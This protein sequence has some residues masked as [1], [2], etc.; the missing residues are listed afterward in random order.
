MTLPISILLDFLVNHPDNVGLR[1][2]NDYQIH[3]DTK[4]TLI[5]TRK[6]K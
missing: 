2:K 3:H 4:R 5:S 1:M 6:K